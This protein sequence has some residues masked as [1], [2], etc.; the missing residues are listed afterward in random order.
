MFGNSRFSPADMAVIWGTVAAMAALF[1]LFA[2]PQIAR[3]KDAA[4]LLQAPPS[5]RGAQ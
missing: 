4:M 3:Q 1:L 2:V 5:P